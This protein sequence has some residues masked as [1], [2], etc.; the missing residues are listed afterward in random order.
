MQQPLVGTAEGVD[1]VLVQRGEELQSGVGA[2]GEE[3]FA[4]LTLQLEDD[5]VVEHRTCRAARLAADEADLTEDAAGGKLGKELLAA[6]RAHLSL[7]H[8]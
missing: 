4:R 2:S 8:I 5:P 1:Q 6:A 3:G 7:I